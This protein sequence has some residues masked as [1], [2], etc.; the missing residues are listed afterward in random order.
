MI[1]LL[2]KEENGLNGDL[3]NVGLKNISLYNASIKIGNNL[4]FINLLVFKVTKEREDTFIKPFFL[5]I[6]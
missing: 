5:T 6:I 4:P 3:D 1:N 2:Y